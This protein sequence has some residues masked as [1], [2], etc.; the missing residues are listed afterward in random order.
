[1]ENDELIRWKDKYKNNW[2]STE[3]R[4]RLWQSCWGVR[5]Q[6]DGQDLSPVGWQLQKRLGR[7]F[8]EGS[9]YVSVGDRRLWQLAEAHAGR[10]VACGERRGQQVQ[11]P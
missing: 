8:S 6:G 1:M 11:P 7:F 9:G 10:L 2:S 4:A 3:T 5:S